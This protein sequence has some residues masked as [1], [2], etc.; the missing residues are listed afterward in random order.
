MIKKLLFLG[1]YVTSLVGMSQSTLMNGLLAY[2]PFNGN[3]LDESGN[4]KNGT[5]VGSP[6]LTTD[7]F[8][9]ANKAYSFDG[10][11]WINTSVKSIPS[12]RLSLCA[13]IKTLGNSSQDFITV[14]ASR[15]GY[16]NANTLS[17][18]KE[19]RLITNLNAGTG[20]VH[21]HI[22]TTPS[23]VNNIWHFV[24]LTYDGSVY[25]TYID[26]VLIKQTSDSFSLVV[27]SD[28]KIG[29]DD[30][31]GY[32]SRNFNGLIDDVR[33]YDRALTAN[34]VS[35]LNNETSCSQT[36]SETDMLV[37][38]TVVTNIDNL[39]YVN[40]IKIY[41]N[42]VSDNHLTIDYGNYALLSGYKIQVVNST[43][44]SVFENV[45]IQAKSEIDL[46][47]WTGS[48]IYYVRLYDTQGNTLQ[49]RKIVLQ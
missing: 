32:S 29:N 42:P 41:P 44:L 17:I 40:N 25:K 15:T 33:I 31:A 39:S 21:Q 24:V 37:L 13:W 4:G 35:A 43:G 12:G 5:F 49:V 14:I 2:Y 36:S 30:E 27:G 20:L 10:T 46:S 28:F 11:S 18:D 23:L 3:A 8:G 19:S 38:K 16:C 48:G 47:A 34:E 9:T 45:V 26:G 7:R 6:T 1:F 22:I